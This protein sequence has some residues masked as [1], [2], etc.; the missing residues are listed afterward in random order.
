MNSS[1]RTRALI[2]SAMMVA[3]A[4]VLSI[5][6]IIEMPYGGSVT[7]ASALP[8]AVLAYRHGFKV[9]LGA[10]VVFAMLQQLLGLKT[11]AYFTTW[12]SIVAIIL[13][14]YLVAF[15]LFGLGGVFKST[16]LEQKNALLF[17]AILITVLRYICHVIS[18]A[19]VWAGLSIPTEAA[20]I[21][22]LGYNATYMIPEGIILAA[23]AYYLGSVIDFS[24]PVPERMAARDKA[25]GAPYFA[26][27]GLSLLF[28]VIADTTLIAP[29]LQDGNSG[30][31][32]FKY[33]SEVSWLT[34]AVITALCIAIFVLFLLLAKRARKE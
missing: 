23:C 18:G 20:L 12:Q 24:R 27:S 1:Q 26:V 31:F 32:T 6:K 9:G 8:I 10:G 19:T 4:T 28:A 34:V 16:R 5:I 22:S 14:D 17:G 2:E 7:I 30:E 21:Y 15:T 29:H 13:L 33:L 25:D 3:L 11:L